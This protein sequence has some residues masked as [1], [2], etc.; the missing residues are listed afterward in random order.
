MDREVKNGGRRAGTTIS[1]KHQITIPKGAM[2]D[3]GLRH[4]DRLRV[5]SRGRG[6]VL[7]VRV[8]DPV[9]RHAGALTGVFRPRELDKLRDEWD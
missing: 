6:R 3:A 8:E 1:S 2:A 4:G 5:E 9:R 7:L